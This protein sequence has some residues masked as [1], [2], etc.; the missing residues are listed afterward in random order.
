MSS[1]KTL[2]R[3]RKASDNSNDNSGSILNFMAEFGR[4]YLSS[5]GPTSRLEEALSALGRKLGYPTEV[6][7]TPTGIFVSCVSPDGSAHTTLSR[8][9][10]GGINLETLCWLEGIFEDVYDRKIT[11]TQANRIL[12][13]K[14]MKKP[15]YTLWQTAL[16]SLLAGF[17]LSYPA[18]GRAGAAIVSG[19]IATATWWISGP[20]LK[21]RVSSSIF[22]D[23]IGC[24]VTLG[25]AAACQIV[26]PAPFEAYTIGGLI[27]LVPGLALTTAIAE[28]ADQNLV[29]GT[30][31]LMQAVLTLL[32]LGLA[33]LLFQELTASL[34]V[35]AMLAS[36]RRPQMALPVALGSAVIS[37]GC[38]G[39][40]FK[41]PPRSL[42]WSTATGILG[43]V[44]LRFFSGSQH[45]AIAS[46]LA[47]LAVGL[48]SLA[49]GYRFKVPSQVYSV[50]G[51]IAML[52]GMLALTSFRSFT[53]GQESGGIELAF[54]VAL[55]AGSIVFGLFTARIPF[56]LLLRSGRR[57]SDQLAY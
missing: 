36:A 32:A 46:Y 50:P 34:G 40:I 16:A 37:L 22:R 44:V 11:L 27:V 52:P 15:A 8:I 5:G 29:S 23:F 42:I 20:G 4:A 53:M 31:K 48:V 45:I 14:V 51:I 6:F 30:A 47:S 9:K 39:V 56:V 28:L 26:F 13:S 21:K 24:I 41:V 17:A 19:V 57:G 55:T 43:W 33:Y 54:K 35:E 3:A 18:F 25:M 1:G 38:F 12:H 10:D 49:L 7:A 2:E